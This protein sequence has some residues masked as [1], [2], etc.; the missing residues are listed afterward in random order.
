MLYLQGNDINIAFIEKIVD[1]LED[2]KNLM[3]LGVSCND[4]LHVITAKMK[5]LTRKEI[6]NHNYTYV[7]LEC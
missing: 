4:E 3:G 6:T 2:N 5:K 7:Q 1:S